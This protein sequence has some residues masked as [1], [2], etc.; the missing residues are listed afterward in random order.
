MAEQIDPEV[1]QVDP[2]NQV[3]LG[4]LGAPNDDSAP[5]DRVEPGDQHA[6]TRN[7]HAD[8]QRSEADVTSAGESPKEIERDAESTEGEGKN[9][10]KDDPAASM[11]L[12]QALL[13][14][15]LNY[16]FSAVE[17]PNKG[18]RKP[19]E[20]AVLLAMAVLLAFGATVAAKSLIAQESSHEAALENLREQIERQR[21]TVSRLE[22]ENNELAASIALLSS[23]ERSQVKSG[24]SAV[25]HSQLDHI[26][27][28][29]LTVR[30][31]E[32][33]GADGQSRVL[34]NDVRVVV[35]ALWS[36]GAEGIEI[37]GQRIGPTTAIR[38]AGRTILINFKPTVSP[39]EIRVIGN[40][41]DLDRALKTG[42]TGDYLSTLYSKYGIGV[43]IT[44]EKDL[45]LEPA[46]TRQA[47]STAIVE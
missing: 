42:T 3:D 43:D 35:N 37:N 33:D 8:S 22:A 17:T 36:E 16:G 1:D 34:D 30:M 10:E 18:P 23:S 47:T 9:T 7:I 11:S 46:S 13:Y 27:G 25:S 41:E 15:P 45:V 24:D 12:L 29:G 5:G 4:D 26:H 40:P 21:D 38:T 19:L 44:V 14:D 31:T 20:T 32:Q 6:S 39:Y 2:D 28:P